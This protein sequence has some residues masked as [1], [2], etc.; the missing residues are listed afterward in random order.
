MFW[1]HITNYCFKLTMLFRKQIMFEKSKLSHIKFAVKFQNIVPMYEQKCSAVN[2]FTFC[3]HLIAVVDETTDVSKS[4]NFAK[5]IIIMVDKID[6]QMIV[7]NKI[8]VLCYYFGLSLKF[9]SRVAW[10][11]SFDSYQWKW[12]STIEHAN[13]PV[14]F[15]SF[16]QCQI[17][18]NVSK[19]I[20][21]IHK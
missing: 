16:E 19:C 10:C 18:I 14:R 3:C 12:L 13:L 15:V 7:F 5:I 4:H 2:M 9:S 6:L 8:Y 21:T 20:S 1:K 11:A 17:T